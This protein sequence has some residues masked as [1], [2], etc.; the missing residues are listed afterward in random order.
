M[1]LRS[2]SAM[3]AGRVRPEVYYFGDDVE[4]GGAGGAALAFLYEFVDW[5][6]PTFVPHT[7]CCNAGLACAQEQWPVGQGVVQRAAE[8]RATEQKVAA[9]RATEQRANEQRVAEQRVAEQ[10]VAEQRTAEQRATEQ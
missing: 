8:Q 4:A 9:R 3:A 6:L 5:C 1:W 7:Q 2:R 10:R